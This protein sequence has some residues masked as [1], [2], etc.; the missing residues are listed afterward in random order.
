M[1][2]RIFIIV[3]KVIIVCIFGEVVDVICIDYGIVVNFR[4]KD[5]IESLIKVGVELKIIEEM[6]EMVE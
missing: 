3:D 2:V 4:R 5:L 1:R 6:K